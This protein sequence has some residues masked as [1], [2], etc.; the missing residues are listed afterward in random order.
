MLPLWLLFPNFFFRDFPQLFYQLFPPTPPPK[1]SF[2]TFPPSFLPHFFPN[3]LPNFSPNFSPNVFPTTFS[4]Q[5]SSP[6]FHW[7]FLPDLF[8]T[9]FNPQL[10]HKIC[11][12]F[13]SYF[14]SS[15]CF[16]NFPPIFFTNFVPNLVFCFF[17][18]PSSSMPTFL[19]HSFIH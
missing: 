5:R 9:D 13:F 12:N 4:H 1:L 17:S 15:V 16:P 7:L 19:I 11:L 6:L 18:C 10:C 8:F 14:V 2:W 3:F